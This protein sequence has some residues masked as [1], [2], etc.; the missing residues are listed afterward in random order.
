MVNFLV[1]ITCKTIYAPALI[2]NNVT[3]LLGKKNVFL[4]K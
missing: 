3:N 1:I 2:V 4:R